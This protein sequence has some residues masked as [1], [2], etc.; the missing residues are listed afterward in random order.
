[1]SDPNTTPE[2]G[3]RPIE[4][5]PRDGR[6]IDLWHGSGYRVADAQWVNN[7][8]RHGGRTRRAGLTATVTAT[9]PNRS[10][11]GRKLRGRS[12]PKSPSLP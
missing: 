6:P 10:P 7:V 12:F 9:R 1:M 8:R 11:I 4:T 5:A 3:W 2:T